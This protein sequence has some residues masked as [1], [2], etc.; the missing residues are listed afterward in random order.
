M[1]HADGNIGGVRRITADPKKP[2]PDAAL[3]EIAGRIQKLTYAEM[4]EL[5]GMFE[6][7]VRG[8]GY[9]NFATI[10]LTISDRILSR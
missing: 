7:S 3:K 1:S 8:D 5:T 4:T 2:D 10:L 9:D 6:N